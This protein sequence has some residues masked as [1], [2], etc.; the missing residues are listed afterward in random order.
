[1]YENVHL[2]EGDAIYCMTIVDAMDLKNE[3]VDLSV[4]VFT[5]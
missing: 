5:V 1:M 4:G 2:Y 3:W